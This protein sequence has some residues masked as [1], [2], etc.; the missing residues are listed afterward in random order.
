[1]G[2]F[3]GVLK[4]VLYVPS[5]ATNMLFVYHM[6]H[7]SLPKRVVFGLGSVEVLDISTG[8]IRA[9]GVANH[10]SKAYEFSQF[11]PYSDLV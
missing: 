4:D 2:S 9:K 7:T 5:L 11:F 3:H 8:K 1:M 10:A 6:T